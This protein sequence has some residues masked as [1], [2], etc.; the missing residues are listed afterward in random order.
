GGEGRLFNI[1]SFHL[2]PAKPFTG[3]ANSAAKVTFA[4]GCSVLGEKDATLFAE[5]VNLAHD[6]DVAL[7][8]VG[9]DA[10]VSSE[11]QDRSAIG[12]PGAQEELVQAIHAANPRTILVI[13]TTCP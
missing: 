11:G 3:E 9:A 10:Q 13:S 1:E 5:A 7:V 8:F 2:T 12:L 4:M 6:A